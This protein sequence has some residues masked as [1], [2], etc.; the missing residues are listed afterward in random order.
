M[1]TRN[2]CEIFNTPVVSKFLMKHI[3]YHQMEQSYIPVPY[4]GVN[5]Q[6]VPYC[7]NVLSTA[8]A[9]T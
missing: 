7:T 6:E 4:V 8:A 2:T 5:S 9:I 1:Q 3:P